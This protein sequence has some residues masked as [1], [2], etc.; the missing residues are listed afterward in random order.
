MTARER[1]LA[2]LQ[3]REPDRVPVDLG[4]TDITT[5]MVG[6]YVRV[7]ESLGVD[8]HPIYVADTRGQY[9]IVKGEV[10][11]AVGSNSNAQVVYRRPQAW[12]DGEA[13]DGTPILVPDRFRPDVLPD[14]SRLIGDD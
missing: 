6:P 5:M 13:Y 1:I 9:V 14:G 10:A 2:A 7:V 4:G 3:H 11:D 8:P 12:R